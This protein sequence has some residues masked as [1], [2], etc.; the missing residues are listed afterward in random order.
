MSEKIYFSKII[1]KIFKETRTTPVSKKRTFEGEAVLQAKSFHTDDLDEREDCHFVKNLL[2]L[3]IAYA[4]ASVQG[5]TNAKPDVVY[6]LR[7]PRFPDLDEP[8]LSAGTMAEIEVAPGLQHAFF[9]V[10]NK[11]S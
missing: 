6:D 4:D 9:S 11:G 8:V 2:P 7:C 3:R 10:D 1:S 5:V